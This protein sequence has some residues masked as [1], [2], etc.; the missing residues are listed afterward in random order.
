MGKRFGRLLRSLQGALSHAT[1][2]EIIRNA[3]T[4]FLV[5]ALGAIAAFALNVVLGRIYGA[6]IVGLYQL[7]LSFVLIA[8]ML[9]RFGME[10]SVTRFVAAAVASN[11][12]PAAQGV[13][14]AAVAST[15]VLGAILTGL[16]YAFAPW[17][18]E[19]LVEK[20]ELV[21]PLRAAA[22]AIVPLALTFI[23]ASTLRGLGNLTGFALA[24]GNFG[25]LV[26]AFTVVAVLLVGVDAGATGMAIAYCAGCILTLGVAMALLMRSGRSMRAVKGSFRASELY[27]SCIPLLWGSIWDV[28]SVQLIMVIVG[29]GL[30]NAEVGIFGMAWK[31]AVAASTAFLAIS[32]SVGPKFSAAF[33]RGDIATLAAT[34]R[35]AMR[36]GLVVS[37]PLF[38]LLVLTPGWIMSFY[39]PEFREGAWLLVILSLGQFTHVVAGPA[40]M[41]LAMSGNERIVGRVH[42]LGGAATIVLAI[43]AVPLF[44]A[45]GVAVSV[46]LCV[47]A[48][49]VACALAVRKLLGVSPF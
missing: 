37:T 12:W 28:A 13:F 34:A 10:N 31:T 11:K 49:N 15:M 30:S 2:R 1:S 39:G 33:A 19:T 42:S 16:L 8:G 18:S 25:P 38:L 29:V 22:M 32:V 9:A 6:D 46:A 36:L 3:S 23:L 44:G 7:A 43:A 5:R 35:R 4:V 17:L 47:A 40:S 26:P 21:E 41:M 27:R 48:K 45:T 14:Q 20:P 24:Q